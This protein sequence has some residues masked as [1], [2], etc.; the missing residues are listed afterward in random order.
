MAKVNY[1]HRK[2]GSFRFD[3]GSL[4]LNFAATVRHR[5]SAPRELLSTPQTLSRWL[6]EAGLS[7][8]PAVPKE[9]EYR[10]ALALRESF[11]ASIRAL[12]LKQKVKAGD[13]QRIN[14][15]AAFPTAAPQLKKGSLSVEWKTPK[16]IVSELAAVARDAVAV[17]AAADRGRLKICAHRDCRMLFVDASPR[18]SRRWCSMSICGNREKVA[19]HRQRQRIAKED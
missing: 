3:A 17:M 9:A 8:T 5:G 7:R 18:R 15:V 13:I 16:P 14:E 6:R 4:S 11:H 12:V 10:L 19:A 1:S 2:Y